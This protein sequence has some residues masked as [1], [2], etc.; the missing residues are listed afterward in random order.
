[1]KSP[2]HNIAVL[3]ATH[4]G[5]SW[6]E[7]QVGSVLNQANVDVHIFVSDDLSTDS[8]VAW[9]TNKATQ[10]DR[11][12][13]LPVI[14]KFGRAGE[15]FFRL[16]R[17]VDLSSYDYVA[18]CDQD[19]IW[20]RDKLMRHIMLA[21]SMH[22]EGVSSNVLAFWPNNKKRLIVKSQ[23]QRKW[24][25]LF[26]SA[27]PGCTF[28]MT[29]WLVDE[30]K[31]QLLDEASPARDVALH[32]WLTYAICRAHGRKWIIDPI[33]SVRYR[34][35]Q[36]NVIGANVGLKAK[37]ARIARIRQHWYRNEIMKILTVCARI[38]NDREVENILM[39]LNQ[40]GLISRVK[41]LSYVKEARRSF[42]DRVMLALAIVVGIF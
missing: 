21:K 3:M 1:M 22:A 31:K 16:I 28:L 29:P 27:G 30:V 41:L 35:H 36:L 7:Q 40:H 2:L 10:D 25:F 37:L 14:D 11:I 38:S 32:D 17:D 18:F 15:N 5:M 6:I 13:F 8:T 26:E 23:T 19:D 39:L 42:L 4:N 34:Q 33:P 20:D 24:D 12:S 9:I